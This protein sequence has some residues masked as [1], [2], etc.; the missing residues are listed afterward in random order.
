MARCQLLTFKRP[1]MWAWLLRVPFAFAYTLLSVSPFFF[2]FRKTPVLYWTVFVT[3]LLPLFSIC[4][5]P[6]RK[7][8]N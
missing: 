6:T 3:P 7:D 2:S 5:L 8:L 4:Q 1:G